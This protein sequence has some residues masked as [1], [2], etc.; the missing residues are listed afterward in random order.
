[1]NGFSEW[2][3]RNR[4]RRPI[5]QDVQNEKSGSEEKEENN[6]TLSL[7]AVLGEFADCTD[8]IHRTFPDIQID[9]IYFGHLV[10]ASELERDVI[11]PVT[12]V[13][14]DE[15]DRLFERSQYRPVHTMKDAVKSI[16]DGQAALFYRNKVFLVD[17]YGP[18]TRSIQP[19]ETETVIVGPHDSFVENAGTNLSLIRRRVK[20]SHLKVIKLSVGEITKTDVYLLYILDIVNM[21]LVQELERRIRLVEIDAI[22][23]TT[24]L[25]QCIDECPNSIFPQFITTERPDVVASKLVDGKIVTLVEGSPMAFSAP[26]GFFEFVQ[27]P[28]DYNQRW[29]LGTFIR[30]LRFVALTITVVLTALYV[31]ITTYHYEMIPENMLVTLAES[32][33]KVPFPPIYEALL[34]EL[35]IELLREAG[36]RLPTKIGQTIGIVGGIVIGQAVVQAGFTS[37][38]LII[39]VAISAISSFAIPS[40]MMSASIRLIRFMLIVL[41]GVLGNFGILAG[42]TFVVIHLCG[43]TSLGTPYLLPVAP[44][45]FADWKDAFIR[46]PFWMITQRSSQSKLPNK[47]RNRMRQ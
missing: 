34:L 21:D 14:A 39:T 43:L 2:M 5:Q 45:Y 23:S 44:L 10:G 18:E 15:A 35:T 28:D 12:N 41:A 32:R 47:T 30:F 37:N 36:A 7:T 20:S 42:I 11:L 3:R 29:P 6:Q 38:I 19:S 33:S 1:M 46:A 4:P 16:L 25:V 27:S 24:M 26:T 8:L 31:A 9:L 17:V 22:H 13:Q 40:Y